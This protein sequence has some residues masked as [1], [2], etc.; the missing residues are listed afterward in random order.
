MNTLESNLTPDDLFG[1][2]V[3]VQ[4]DH[5]NRQLPYE[6][7]ER[8][9]ASRMRAVA[10][11]RISQTEWQMASEVQAQNGLLQMHFPSKTQAFF[12]SLVSLI[13]L[14]C[15]AAGLVILYDFHNEQ[16]ASEL[17]EVDTALLI[18]DL[19]PQAYADPGFAHFLKSS[20]NNAKD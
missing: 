6:I 11:R 14:I 18:D 12:N 3:A 16:S 7:T 4:L 5:S 15:L 2:R 9:R 20:T 13:P 19:P 10:L 17:A 1:R 8:L